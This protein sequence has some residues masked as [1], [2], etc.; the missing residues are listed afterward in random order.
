MMGFHFRPSRREWSSTD[1]E[2]PS[3]GS[4]W[5]LRSH[6]PNRM[7]RATMLRSL[8]F[9]GCPLNDSR[10]VKVTVAG[11]KKRNITRV[12]IKIHLLYICCEDHQ[13]VASINNRITSRC[14]SRHLTDSSSNRY[15]TIP[16]AVTPWFLS[17]QD[18]GAGGA[19]LKPIDQTI[20]RRC[21]RVP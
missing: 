14:Y 2:P 8:A 7:I 17:K 5:G 3:C 6:S 10:A 12:E 9:K 18:R 13:T 16:S 4:G 15:C 11:V 21:A 19:R 1:G 20:I